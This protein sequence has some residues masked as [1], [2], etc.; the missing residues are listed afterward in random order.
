MVSIK[1]ELSVS[2]EMGDVAEPGATQENLNVLSQQIIGAAIEVHR[3]L[4]PGLMESVYEVC[5]VR[6][7]QTRGLV[8]ETQV[9]VPVVYKGEIVRE[10]GFRLDVLVNNMVVVELKSVDRVTDVHKKQLLTYLRLAEKQLG[11]LINF[12]ELV[13]KRGITRIVSGFDD[14]FWE[15]P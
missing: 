2:E 9:P 14:R 11:L 6:E 12:N 4:G 7:L 10:D 1:G 15:A 5:I 13:L 3:Q 8:A